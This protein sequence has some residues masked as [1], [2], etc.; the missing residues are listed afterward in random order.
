MEAEWI[1]TQS[2]LGIA[3]TRL[4]QLMILL[5]DWGS[6][7][8]T[9]LTR[10]LYAVRVCEMTFSWRGFSHP[11]YTTDNLAPDHVLEALAEVIW[12]L[13]H[14]YWDTGEGIQANINLAIAIRTVTAA[15]KTH[16]PHLRHQHSW[17]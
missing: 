15:G 14:H 4:G 8:P 17:G 5:K 16:T 2:D 12:R 10:L 7:P 11:E 9:L 6:R 1:Q 13:I 3:D